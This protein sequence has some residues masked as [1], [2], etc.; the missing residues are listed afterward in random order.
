MEVKEYKLTPNPRIIN[1]EADDDIY[2]QIVIGNRQIGGNHISSNG[3]EIIRGDLSQKAFLGKANELANQDLDIIT[4]VLDV[5]P[6]TNN[7]VITTTFSDQKDKA[8]FS[9]VDRGEA[10]SNGIAQFIGLYKVNIIALILILFFN[11]INLYAQEKVDFTDL[12]TP[13][14]PG[15]ILL[16]ET[17]ASVENSTTPEGLAVSLLNLQ[18]ENS[19]IEFAPFWLKDHNSLT[20]DSL[21]KIRIPFWENLSISLATVNT[22]TV[23]NLAIGIRSRLFQNFSKDQ[24]DSLKTIKKR[25]NDELSKGKDLDLNR[26]EELREQYVNVALKPQIS[27]DFAAAIS[28]STNTNSYNDLE[29]SRWAAWASFS[30]RPKADDFYL[31]A[32]TRYI[33]NDE[34]KDY[35]PNTDL[36]D[37]GVRFNYDIKTAYTASLEYVHRLNLTDNVYHDYRLAAIGSYKLNDNIYLTTTLGKNFTE[38]DNVIALAGLSFGISKTKLK[39]YD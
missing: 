11:S 38:V 12:K 1:A 24:T 20:A 18:D 30:W 28:S 5:N 39:A 27:I 17:P 29:P 34:F 36:F 2:I 21:N 19:A 10:P 8:L 6:A 26:L 37:I 16:D 9:K 31:T 33:R 13:T 23:D 4:N 14:S 15:F 3:S 22:D 35:D 32:L 25:I 7:C